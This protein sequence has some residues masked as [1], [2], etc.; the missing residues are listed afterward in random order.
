V[1]LGEL[2]RYGEWLP[3]QP[4]FQNT[5]LV[6]AKNVIPIDG[7]YK[8]FLQ[9]LTSDDALAE[10]PQGAYAAID[11]AGD[12]E[13]YAGTETKLLEKVGTAWTD[14]SP[15]PYATASNGYWR[16]VQFDALVIATNFNNNIQSKTVGAAANFADLDAGAPKARQIGVINRFVVVGDTDDATNGAVPYRIQWCAINDPTDWPVI[17][18]ADARSKQS[19][20]QFMDASYGAVT[21]IAGGQFFGLVF[22][23]RAIT[24][25]TYVGGDIVFQFDTF[26]KTSG[27]W[28]P[29][30]LMQVGNT[31]YLLAAD[32]WYVTDGQSAVPIGTGRFDK[33]FYSDF[34]Q[35]YRERLTCALDLVS[36]VIYWSYPSPSATAGVP[37]KL[38]VYNFIEKRASWAEETVQMIFSSFTQGYTL[39]QLDALFTSI[40]DMTISLDSSMWSGGIPT[41]MGFESNTMG[42][43]SGAALVARF[44]TG[45][46]EIE[47]PGLVYLNGVKPIVTGEPTAVTVAVSVRSSQDNASRSFG[48]ATNRTTRTGVCDFRAHG[49]YAS[50]RIDLT[51]GFD[52]AIG[53]QFEGSPGDGV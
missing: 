15:A 24:R 53:I 25:L 44:E 37:D 28:A 29:Q 42:T 46:T 36:K 20:E 41:V 14:R 1:S 35:T 16:F 31:W 47:P 18:T 38:L 2:I 39:E 30:S 21:A 49:R 8:D 23:Q 17:G 52:R 9:I 48:A 32:G 34:D 26:E 27:C 45:E 50:A 3:D 7:S 43:F 51:G 33:T 22:Q 40:D 6:E 11:D 12:P 4:Y 10:R 5:G 19:G 13:I